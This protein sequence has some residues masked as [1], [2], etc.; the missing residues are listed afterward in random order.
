MSSMIFVCCV[1]RKF[2]ALPCS[3]TV[4]AEAFSRFT[5][6]HTLF[7]NRSTAITQHLYTFCYVVF[8]ILICVIHISMSS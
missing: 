2:S 6:A 3:G 5:L 4:D 1:I 7:V 8:S